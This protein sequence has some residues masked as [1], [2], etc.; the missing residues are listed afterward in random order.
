MSRAVRRRVSRRGA[1]AQR[2]LRKRAH[3]GT[4][5]TK[6]TKKKR[7]GSADCADLRGLIRR[8]GLTRRR[9]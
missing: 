5:F 2:T 7:M 1:E 3:K 8:M 6:D 9:G 4:G